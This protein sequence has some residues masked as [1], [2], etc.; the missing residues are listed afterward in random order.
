MRPA[1]RV[2]CVSSTLRTGSCLWAELRWEPAS[3]ALRHCPGEQRQQ[4]QGEGSHHRVS[5]LKDCLQPGWWQGFI[6][7]LVV[8]PSWGLS[9]VGWTGLSS[10]GLRDVGRITTSVEITTSRSVTVVEVVDR[11]VAFFVCVCV[12]VCACVC[13]RW[14]VCL[15][16]QVSV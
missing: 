10:K 7:P 13:V 9:K 15:F 1:G 3:T 4:D 14:C 5:P 2:A 11:L 12:H 8:P 6:G 16:V